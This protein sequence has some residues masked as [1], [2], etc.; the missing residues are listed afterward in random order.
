[1][2][3]TKLT[4]KK[5]AETLYNWPNLATS[6]RTGY[7]CPETGSRSTGKDEKWSYANCEIEMFII[8]PTT[9]LPSMHSPTKRVTRL[10]SGIK[11]SRIVSSSVC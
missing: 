10:K 2:P 8:Q 6:G 3:N 5:N 1:M 11:L 9:H 4:L 7:C